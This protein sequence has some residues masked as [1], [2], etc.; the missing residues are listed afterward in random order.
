MTVMKKKLIIIAVLVIAF[1]TSYVFCGTDKNDTWIDSIKIEEYTAA[2][3]NKI[4]LDYVAGT[5]YGI[6]PSNVET[7]LTLNADGTYLL[8]RTFKEKQNEREKLRGVFQM[9]DGNVL[10]LV[11]PSSGDNIF[12]KVRDINSIILIDSFG[13]EPK[14]EGRRKNE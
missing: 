12:Y 1:V 14:K 8:T 9:L 5:Y 4:D 11:H 6:L 3:S 13:N 10:M 2:L 7:T